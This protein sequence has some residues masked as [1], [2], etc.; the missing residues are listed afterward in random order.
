MRILAGVYGLMNLIVAA[1]PARGV[2]VALEFCC[3]PQPAL[4]NPAC[5]SVWECHRIDS[6]A[7]VID[8]GRLVDKSTLTLR[9]EACPPCCRENCP[10]SQLP[11]GPINSSAATE[12]SASRTWT[13][14]IHPSIGASFMGQLEAALQ[15]P[16][17]WSG[18][19]TC[20]FSAQVSASVPMCRVHEH[21]AMLKVFADATVAV[22]HTFEWRYGIAPSPPECDT[23]PY[24]PT[25]YQVCP[26]I[27]QSRCTSDNWSNAEIQSTFLG[28][29]PCP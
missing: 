1:E 3:T 5:M 18:Q 12:L 29:F 2:P 28:E 8:P 21:R 17:G 11:Q 4:T 6:A 20:A 10:P 24:S 15:A 23:P 14:E 9:A 25:L 27:E 19:T 13:F 22:T 26:I 16:F 7:S